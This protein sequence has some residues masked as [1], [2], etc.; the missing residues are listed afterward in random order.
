M[1][2]PRQKILTC[3]VKFLFGLGFLVFTGFDVCGKDDF[4]LK[5]VSFLGVKTCLV[6]LLELV[7][8]IG[9]E[10]GGLDLD[11]GLLDWSG[12][13]GLV[14]TGLVG[15]GISAWRTGISNSSSELSSIYNKDLLYLYIACHLSVCLN[16]KNV[17]TAEPIGAIFFVN[18]VRFWK[19][20][21]SMWWIFFK[22]CFHLAYHQKTLN[23]KF[24]DPVTSDYLVKAIF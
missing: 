8:F 21:K 19:S 16:P 11:P 6:C 14:W 1:K 15:K 22:F 5:E 4:V 20:W 13:D 9:L 12:E 18:S 7:W 17:K 2:T 3:F 24:Q 10:C 23:P